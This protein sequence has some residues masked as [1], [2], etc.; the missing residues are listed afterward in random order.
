MNVTIFCV[1]LGKQHKQVVLFVLIGIAQIICQKENFEKRR[2]ERSSCRLMFQSI[3][4]FTVGHPADANFENG[5]VVLALRKQQLEQFDELSNQ[6]LSVRKS[7]DR[8]L[9]IIL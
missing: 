9:L 5:Q 7:V 6:N 2:Q 8:I 4:L 1:A 3:W